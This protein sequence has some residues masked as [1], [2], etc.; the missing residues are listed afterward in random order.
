MWVGFHKAELTN[1]LCFLETKIL[2]FYCCWEFIERLYRDLKKHGKLTFQ[3][4]RELQSSLGTMPTLWG[5]PSLCLRSFL[6][7]TFTTITDC[8]PLSFFPFS[9]SW[10]NDSFSCNSLSFFIVERG[11]LFVCSCCLI[12][13]ALHSAI[14]RT[15]F[16]YTLFHFLL[17]SLW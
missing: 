7:T 9:V 11:A 17:L 13:S 10:L 6:T 4:K 12:R 16:P 15:W 5:L 3:A 14:S 8:L 1:N 2:P